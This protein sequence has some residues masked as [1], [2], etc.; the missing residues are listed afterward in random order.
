MDLKD[1]KLRNEIESVNKQ[2]PYYWHRRIAWTLEWWLEKARRLMKKFGIVAKTRKTKRFVK[3]DDIW[4][5]ELEIPNLTKDLIVLKPN[6]VWRTDFTFLKYRW[7]FFYLATVLDD[8]TKEIMWYSIWTNHT[9]EFVLLALK[10][11]I[12]KTGIIPIIFHSDQWSEYR[13]YLV[14][15]YL[16]KNNIQISMSPKWQPWKNW[17]QES[18]FWKFKLEI[19]NLNN[20]DTF[21]QAIEAIHHQIYYYNNLRM[22][23]ALRMS[24]I[25]FRKKFELNFKVSSPERNVKIS[26]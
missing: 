5:E 1:E 20:Y 16:T 10:D 21:E 23:T 3:K 4:L 11:A 24:P 18:Y 2:H 19:W 6:H 9:K 13:S 22:H 15:E 25:S 17:S 26:A 7:A 14:L 12:R 8:F